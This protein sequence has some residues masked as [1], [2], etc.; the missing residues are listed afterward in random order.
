MTTRP[1]KAVDAKVVDVDHK[2]EP[3]DAVVVADKRNTLGR[4]LGAFALVLLVLF[5]TINGYIQSA[6]NGDKATKAN[7]KI[8]KLIDINHNLSK[9]VAG[10]TEL[11]K[12]LQDSQRKQNHILAK[13]G[14]RTTP[15]PGESP[16]ESPSGPAN[17]SANHPQSHP[18]PSHS[19][20]PK[21]HPSKTPKPPP[22]TVD[23]VKDRVCSITG[24][25]IIEFSKLL[26]IF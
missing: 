4:R 15:V 6:K 13:H 12:E 1:R 8:D 17:N 3:I 5:F 23:K 18:N 20:H 22:S 24:I 19:P 10:Q 26:D 25:C 2:V 14:L 16:S 21:P 9:T 11:I 7:H